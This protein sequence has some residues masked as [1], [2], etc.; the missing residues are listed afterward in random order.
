MLRFYHGEI[1][2]Q[3]YSVML[4]YDYKTQNRHKDKTFTKKQYYCG[5]LAA[6]GGISSVCS[7]SFLISCLIIL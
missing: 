5:F 1:T 3:A 6:I 2:E 7:D 4:N